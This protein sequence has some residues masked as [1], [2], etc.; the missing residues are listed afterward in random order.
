MRPCEIRA[1]V[2]LVKLNQGDREKAILIG[3]DC[4]GALTNAD[5]SR[6]VALHPEA[7]GDV[8]CQSALIEKGGEIQPA[9]ACRVCEQPIPDGA[10]IVV[11]LLGVDLSDHLLV[12]FEL[13]RVLRLGP[14]SHCRKPKCPM[15][16]KKPSRS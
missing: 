3:I 5:Y 16:G 2:E 1:F 4:P 13:Q 6:W 9:P 11:G 8:F 7:G 15:R 14:L 12:E 10:D